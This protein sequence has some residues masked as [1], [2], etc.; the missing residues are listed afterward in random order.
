MNQVTNVPLS[1]C[2]RFV[3][4]LHIDL[5]DI[6]LLDVRGALR[7]D[8]GLDGIRSAQTDD[9]HQQ[10]QNPHDVGDHVEKRISADHFV[11]VILN[12]WHASFLVDWD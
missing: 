9:H 3:R 8:R 4:S 11:G 2:R 10:D 7:R 1:V 5:S 6:L 12:A